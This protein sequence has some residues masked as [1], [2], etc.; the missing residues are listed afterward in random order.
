MQIYEQSS[1]IHHLKGIKKFNRIQR[2]VMQSVGKLRSIP[3]LLGPRGL[4]LIVTQA[5]D[6]RPLYG[7]QASMR[8]SSHLGPRGSWA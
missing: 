4:W 1:M 8:D 5:P 7:P 3:G 6:F 2:Q